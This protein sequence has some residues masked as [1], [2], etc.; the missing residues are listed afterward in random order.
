MPFRKGFAKE[1]PYWCKYEARFEEKAIPLEK[2]LPRSR[3]QR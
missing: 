3:I 1:I 2:D